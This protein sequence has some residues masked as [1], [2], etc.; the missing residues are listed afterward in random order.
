MSKKNEKGILK[1]LKDIKDRK[2][3]KEEIIEKIREI[4]ENKDNLT[5]ATDLIP[6]IRDFQDDEDIVFVIREVLAKLQITTYM[7]NEKGIDREDDND[8]DGA[9]QMY[10]LCLIIDPSYQWAWYNMGRMYGDVK[11]DYERS[12]ECY[13]EAIKIN[14]SYGDAWNNMGNV[15]SKI[16]RFSLA[17]HAYEKSYS[18]PGYTAKHFPYFNLGLLYDKVENHKKA[19]EYYLKSIEIKR[20]Y[21]KAYYNAA[22]SYKKLGDMTKSMDFFARTLEFDSTYEKSVSEQGVSVEEII[23]REIIKK[24]TPPEKKVNNNIEASS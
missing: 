1:I 10:E 7:M 19:I 3:P 14:D 17:K 18:S 24:L 9:I 5:L 11:N 12:I 15:Y 6:L 22:K 4:G 23:A 21:A 20:D 8:P 13:K 16:N 2:L